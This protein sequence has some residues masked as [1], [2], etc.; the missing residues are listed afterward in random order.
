[1]ND[2]I[3]IAAAARRRRPV[4]RAG[5]SFAEVLFAVIILGIG[6]ILVAAIFPVA[7]SQTQ[8][9]AE[10]AGAAAAAREAANTLAALPTTVPNPIYD[11]TVAGP[12]NATVAIDPRTVQTLSLFPPTVR[13]YV[14]PTSPGT[15]NVPPPALVVPFSGPRAEMARA[16]LIDVSD[17]RYAY[18]PFYRREN[19][20]SVAQLIVIA[21][22]ARNR[23]VFDPVADT[24]IPGTSAGSVYAGPANNVVT[25]HSVA[26]ADSNRYT[27]C[28]DLITISNPPAWLCEGCSLQ[29]SAT[30]R[31][32]RLGR[33]VTMTTPP[34]Q[35]ELDPGDNLSIAPG[36]DNLWGS[37]RAT[38]AATNPDDVQDATASTAAVLPPT[39]V[40]PVGAYAT[41]YAAPGSV[42]GR[43]TL[44]VDAVHA[45]R[46]M[47]PSA[48]MPTLLNAPPAAAAPG[49]FVIVADDYPYDASDSPATA[50]SYPL[51]G[52]LPGFTVGALNGHIFRLG[53]LVPPNQSTANPVPPGTFELDPQYATVPSGTQTL[54]PIQP[55][56]TPAT[57]PWARVY[58]VGAGRTAALSPTDPTPANTLT[59]YSGPAQDIGVFTTFFAVP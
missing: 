52:N 9:T 15:L 47:N 25:S 43:I 12:V 49:A 19:G 39:T 31:S 3:R 16:N 24:T 50:T 38:G 57:G 48:A 11:A 32:Y 36:R 33:A 4:G 1:M 28:P 40:Q 44:A 30:G 45:L 21:T 46:G 2:P 23:P 26:M 18:V 59:T 29:T 58:L 22:T 37:F 14:A 34:T 5:F 10:D 53:Q 8:A 54:I 7:I 51:T 41:V 42:S 27:I 17:P 56:G 20:S 13:N 55:S 35:F 6:F